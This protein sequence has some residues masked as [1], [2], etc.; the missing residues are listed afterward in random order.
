M[1]KN[2][3]VIGSVL[4][5]ALLFAVGAYVVK[6]TKTQSVSN[7]ASANEEPFVRAQSLVLGNP[8][9]KVT[10][11]EFFDPA[12]EACSWI[13]PHVKKILAKYPN[14]LKIVI[15]Y[16]PFHKGAD[17][18]VKV[19]E[20]ARKQGKYSQTLEMLFSSQ[21]YWA[22]HN[23]AKPEL[24]NEVLKYTTLDLVQL[25]KDIEHPDIAAILKQDLEDVALLNIKK[26]PSFFVNSKPLLSFGVSQLQDL[27]EAE[28]KLQYP[29]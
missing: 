18:Y 4:M 15:R 25:K 6:Q 17:Y 28:I 11:V 2:I 7:Q 8:N 22:S 10:L 27:V 19:L 1:K 12:C 26:T 13:H 9:A 21:S 20:A 5:M 3:I 23:Q 24:A 29:N 14:K 16:A